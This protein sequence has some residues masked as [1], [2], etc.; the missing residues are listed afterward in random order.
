MIQDR[1]K[2]AADVCFSSMHSS[3]VIRKHGKK[4]IAMIIKDLKQLN[5]GAVPDK[6]VVIPINVDDLT[7]SEKKKH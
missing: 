1:L 6:P 2:T 7:E 5:D 3:K 4:A